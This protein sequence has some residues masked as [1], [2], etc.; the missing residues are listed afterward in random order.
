MSGSLFH[1]GHRTLIIMATEKQYLFFKGLY[2]EENARQTSLADRA[3]VYLSLVTFYSAFVLFAAEK[4]KPDTTALKIIFVGTV[5]STL[6]AFLL[7]LWSIRVSEYEALN[8]PQE[9]ITG[10]GTSPP[11]DEDF[12]DD[13][14]VDFAVAYQRNSIV[15]DRKAVKLSWAGFL[16]LA[17]IFLHACYFFVKIN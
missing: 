9:I 15:N 4:L 16:L 6:A 3:K 1:S 11:E 13:R 5:G 8:D 14:I 2:D 10:F 7:S 17:G 12:F